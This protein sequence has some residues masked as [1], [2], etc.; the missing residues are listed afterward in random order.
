MGRLLVPRAASLSGNGRCLSGRESGASDSAG[1]GVNK[2]WFD[3][4]DFVR[5]GACWC[6]WIKPTLRA[7]EKAQTELVQAEAD[8]KRRELLSTY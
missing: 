1:V 6:C 7:L 2:I 8:L 5:K 3:D 4:T